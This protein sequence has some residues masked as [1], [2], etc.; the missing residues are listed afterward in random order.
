M[1][2]IVIAKS[3]RKLLHLSGESTSFPFIF[4]E[5]SLIWLPTINA[6]KN[7]SSPRSTPC[8]RIERWVLRLLASWYHIKHKRNKTNLAD[9]V[10]LGLLKDMEKKR[11]SRRFISVIGIRNMV[12]MG[13]QRGKQ[14]QHVLES[15]G[16]YI[17]NQSAPVLPVKKLDRTFT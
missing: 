15:D 6:L 11:L 1:P 16:I 4:Q 8:A 17:E 2:R 10:I 7:L 9:F 13:Q 3:K 12:L 5:S 14:S